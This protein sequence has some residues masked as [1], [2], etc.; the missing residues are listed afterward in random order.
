[1][2]VGSNRG[3]AFMDG[4]RRVAG[5]MEQSETTLLA[6]RTASETRLARLIRLVLIVGSLAA[7]LTA[8]FINTLLSR[9]ASAHER[10][11]TELDRSN[12]RLEEQ[13]MERERQSE[14]LTNM[15]EELQVVNSELEHTVQDL[16][17][18]RQVVQEARQ[19]A[20]AAS[21]AKSE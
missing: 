2:I 3:K 8:L 15:N 17:G 10:L 1:M 18:E 21:A 20:E 11:T 4:A 14:E 19:S 5:A 13:A 7:V 6:A 16:E 9:H 12:A